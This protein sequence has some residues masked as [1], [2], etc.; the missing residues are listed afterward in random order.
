MQLGDSFWGRSRLCAF[1]PY[2]TACSRVFFLGEGQAL[3]LPDI[4]DGLQPGDSF[5]GR[6]GR[7]AIQA[8]LPYAKGA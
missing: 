1:Q 5:W 3:C 6:A 7:A 4:P 8:A 2:Q